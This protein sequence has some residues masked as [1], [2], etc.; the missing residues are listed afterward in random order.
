MTCSPDQTLCALW[1]QPSS[2]A[3]G[4]TNLGLQTQSARTMPLPWSPSLPCSS[5]VFHPASPAFPVAV[6]RYRFPPY[7]S[8]AAQA[9]LP[10][11]GPISPLIPALCT[12]LSRVFHP[13]C[14]PPF[15]PRPPLPATS[16]ASFSIPN[17]SPIPIPNSIPPRLRSP[18]PL[19]VPTGCAYPRGVGRAVRSR[20]G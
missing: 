3:P 9:Q 16:P 12:R 17:P 8:L 1:G 18:P 11:P 2:E 7:P 20:R 10:A 19:R 6:R 13:R 14:G 4:L 5:P 15:Q